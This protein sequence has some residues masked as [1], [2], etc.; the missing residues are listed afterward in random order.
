MKIIFLNID[1]VLSN[2]NH[3]YHY[4]NNYIDDN[5]LNL[6]AAVVKSTSSEVVLSSIWKNSTN[7]VSSLISKLSKYNIK[8]LEII[9]PLGQNWINPSEEIKKWLQNH[10]QVTKY[11]IIDNSLELFDSF[12]ENL[13]A[14]DPEL[15]ITEVLALDIIDHMNYAYQ[16]IN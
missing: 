12:K 11:V 16:T 5:L 13:F 2:D 6:F 4:G 10:P 9:S 1:G 8:I 3:T 14:T 7:K 15:G